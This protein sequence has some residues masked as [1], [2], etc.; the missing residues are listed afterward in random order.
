VMLRFFWFIVRFR[1]R[2]RTPSCVILALDH[3]CPLVVV[4]KSPVAWLLVTGKSPHW[5]LTTGN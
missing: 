5:Q 4:W 2:H 1:D 3:F